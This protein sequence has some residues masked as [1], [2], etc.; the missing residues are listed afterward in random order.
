MVID[1]KMPGGKLLTNIFLI[2]LPLILSLLGSSANRKLAIPIEHNSQAQKDPG[3]N[4]QV[5]P[6]VSPKIKKKVF[7]SM[8]NAVFTKNKEHVL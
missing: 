2:K 5:R 6:V 4:G 1:I 7:K 8:E 3:A